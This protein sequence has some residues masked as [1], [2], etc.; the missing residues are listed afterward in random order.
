[1]AHSW[2][3]WRY[4]CIRYTDITNFE[5]EFEK[6][7]SGR[8]LMWL[9]GCSQKIKS[10]RC[11]KLL[12]DAQCGTPFFSHG[13]RVVVFVFLY[14]KFIITHTPLFQGGAAY[15]YELPLGN[16][17]LVRNI[18]NPFKQCVT[19]QYVFKP[20]DVIMLNNCI[21]VATITYATASPSRVPLKGMFHQESAT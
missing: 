20:C 3:M 5:L 13:K 4:L 2:H 12:G 8:W 6:N 10:G 7:N 16:L 21:S 11:T 14:A 17:S 19:S 1:M 9:H 18:H 15:V